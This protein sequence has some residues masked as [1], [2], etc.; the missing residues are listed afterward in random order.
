[1]KNLEKKELY[2]QQKEKK[3]IEIEMIIEQYA[4][5]DIELRQRLRDFKVI[6]LPDTRISNVVS[7]NETLER[8]CNLLKE[9]VERLRAILLNTN[10]KYDKMSDRAT[11]QKLNYTQE[12]LLAKPKTQVGGIE[13]NSN[14]LKMLE[15]T[16]QSCNKMTK[17][18]YN[19]LENNHPQI[20]GVDTIGVALFTP[21][22]KKNKQVYINDL[23]RA[24]KN[25]KRVL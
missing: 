18:Q 14:E 11:Q 13:V 2:M 16:P 19:P 5:D 17:A 1:M 6:I 7:K 4:R 10:S 3:W 15:V 12:Q 23:E 9:E 25:Y 21:D 20:Q 22:V 8:E 24:L